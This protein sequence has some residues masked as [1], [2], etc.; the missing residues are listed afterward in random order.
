MQSANKNADAISCNPGQ[1]EEEQKVEK[2]KADP[3]LKFASSFIYEFFAAKR[4]CGFWCNP[5]TNTQ[6]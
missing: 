2:K 5:K 3:I 6:K 1:I 4:F